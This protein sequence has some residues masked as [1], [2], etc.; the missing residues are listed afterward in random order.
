MRGLNWRLPGRR[1]SP[2][3]RFGTNGGQEG[4]VAGLP[5]SLLCG[6]R[7]HVTG[8]ERRSFQLRVDAENVRKVTFAKLITGRKRK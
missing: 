2:R 4:G 8:D 1:V 7:R 3:G 5:L 6:L